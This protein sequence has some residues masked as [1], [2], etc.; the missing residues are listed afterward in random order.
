MDEGEEPPTEHLPA[1]AHQELLRREG[2]NSGS[3][4]YLPWA[5]RSGLLREEPVCVGLRI[6]EVA[7]PDKPAEGERPRD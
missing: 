2:N 6:C 3:S 7:D 1:P 4:V 5:D